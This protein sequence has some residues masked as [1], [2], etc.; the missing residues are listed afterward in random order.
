M[1][2]LTAS[3]LQ[4]LAQ[5]RFS[6]DEVYDGRYQSKYT[7][8]A[9]AKAAGQVLVLTSVRCRELGHRIRT[10]AGHCAQCK[11]MN[12]AFTSRERASASVYIAGSLSGRVIKIGVTNDIQ[13]RVRQLCAQ[14]YGGFS[15]WSVL[16]SVDV[17]DAGAVER[18]VSSRI[19]GK[20]INNTYFK[21]GVEQMAIE[22]IQ[23]S[24]SA[25]FEAL[26]DSVGGINRPNYWLDRNREYEFEATD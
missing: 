23:C 2:L 11:P 19:R 17:N 22:V 6:E 4:F 18:E 26:A 9:G 8:E 20:R 10:R 25:A 5:Y 13:R 16:I 12:I 24:F 7:R 3:E 21:D 14:G 1:S 15:D